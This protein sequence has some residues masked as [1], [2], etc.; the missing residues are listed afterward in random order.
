MSSIAWLVKYEATDLS[1]EDMDW[2]F[3]NLD[4]QYAGESGSIHTVYEDELPEDAP[5]AVKKLLD[6]AD[7]DYVDIQI[8]W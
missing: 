3:D 7:D 2:I 1:R 5:E 6:D 4:S 8:V